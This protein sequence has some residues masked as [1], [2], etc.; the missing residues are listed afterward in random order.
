M[1]LSNTKF[2]KL[3]YKEVNKIIDDVMNQEMYPYIQNLYSQAIG[4]ILIYLQ[5]NYGLKYNGIM[6]MVFVKILYALNNQD[7]KAEDEQ[8]EMIASQ[9]RPV[10]YRYYKMGLIFYEMI[11]QRWIMR[12]IRGLSVCLPCFIFTVWRKKK[13]NIST[14]LSYPTGR[15]RRPALPARSTG[16]LRHIFLRPLIWPTIRQSGKWCPGSKNI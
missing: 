12:P 10:M 11:H 9:L 4:N 3:I 14:P 7:D 6:E 1:N 8:Y 13:E 2:R 15:R 16:F 5:D